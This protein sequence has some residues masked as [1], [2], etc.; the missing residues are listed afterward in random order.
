[1]FVRIVHLLYFIL[2]IKRHIT[3]MSTNQ[4]Y[5]GCF[6][7]I[8]DVNVN[9]SSWQTSGHQ[10]FDGEQQQCGGVMAT[11]RPEERYTDNVQPLL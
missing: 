8:P 3:V 5:C 9:F 7:V 1:M 6:F 11:T 4:D 2:T 10:G